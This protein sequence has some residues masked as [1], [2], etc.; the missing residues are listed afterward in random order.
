LC[1]EN[2]KQ[3]TANWKRII[4]TGL[5][6]GAAAAQAFDFIQKDQFISGPA[7]TLRDETCVYAQNIT[8]SGTAQDDLFAAGGVL[9][10]RGTFDGDVWGAGE[11][12]IAAGTFG[13]H[14]RLAGRT[15][16][17]AGTVHGSLTAAGTTIKVDDTAVIDGS[18]LAFGENVILEGEIKG[19]AKITGQQVTLGGKIDGD[20]SVTAQDIVV[21]PGTQLNG[22]LNYI[23]PKE[24]VF[25]PTVQHSGSLN[26]IPVPPAPAVNPNLAGHFGFAVAAL[27]TGLALVSIFP[28]Y[29]TNAVQLLRRSRGFCSL[30][31]LA[32]LIL[33]PI[34]IFVLAITFIALP[35][36]I[37]LMLFYL[38]L[39]YL[40]KI[41]AGLWLGTLIL[42]RR[43][44]TRRNVGGTLALGL[45]IIYALM[46]FT[47]ISLVVNLLFTIFGF[48]ALLLA[49][50]KKPVLVIQTPANIQ[51][52]TMEG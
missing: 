29:T 1:E 13:D 39:I 7:E 19:N 18:L 3:K 24:L 2:L 16:Q 47:S 52:K 6:L 48:G 32:A 41:V 44:L 23:S 30:T 42:R 21:L 33:L 43:E 38:I 51:Q 26:R 5:L 46:A 8:I 45:L 25:P 37:V 10:L 40:G 49:L 14:V 4:F 11:Q 36:G 28:R 20:V 27:L 9:D 50:F 34:I 35:L 15:L 31:G 12:V 22:N 17:V